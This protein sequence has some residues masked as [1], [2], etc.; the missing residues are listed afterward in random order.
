M[1]SISIIDTS[2]ESVKS[3]HEAC[4]NGDVKGMVVLMGYVPHDYHTLFNIA[5]DNKSLV[6]LNHLMKNY[7]LL[8]K[9]LA[10]EERMKKDIRPYYERAK[11]S[12]FIEGVEAFE[13]HYQTMD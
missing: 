1:S 13:K 6:S 4:K 11:D 3:L 8:T 10:N 7:D 12:N 5:I 2:A 9:H